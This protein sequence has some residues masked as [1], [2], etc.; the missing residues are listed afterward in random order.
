[1]SILKMQ[2]LVEL[3]RRNRM[4]AKDILKELIKFDTYKDVENKEIMDYIQKT[5]EQ[6][7]FN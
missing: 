2:L 1:M 7:G 6:E 4:Q 3:Q 5:L